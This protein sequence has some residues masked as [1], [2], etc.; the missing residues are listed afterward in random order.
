[1]QESKI[2]ETE[3]GQTTQLSK[4]DFMRPTETWKVKIRANNQ[5]R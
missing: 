1:M 3:E 2:R 4:N 5:P